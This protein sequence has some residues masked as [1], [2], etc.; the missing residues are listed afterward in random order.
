[1]NENDFYIA[2]IIITAIIWTIVWIKFV[3]DNW[4]DK[5]LSAITIVLGYLLG[6]ITVS[7]LWPGTLMAAI[8]YLPIYIIEKIRGH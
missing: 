5:D 8:L 6:G 2:M 3:Y 4:Y 7:L 1:M